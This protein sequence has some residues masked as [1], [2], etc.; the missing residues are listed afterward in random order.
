MEMVRCNAQ[1][2]NTFALVVTENGV[3]VLGYTMQDTT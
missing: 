2:L 1:L 3:L